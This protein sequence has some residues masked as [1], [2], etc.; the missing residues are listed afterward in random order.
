[1]G[2][3]ILLQGHVV[4]VDTIGVQLVLRA[5]WEERQGVKG[6]RL[7]REIKKKKKLNKLIDKVCLAFSVK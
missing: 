4:G 1:M 6:Q 5:S 7:K 3:A 2:T